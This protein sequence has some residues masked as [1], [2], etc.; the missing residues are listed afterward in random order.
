M[1]KK[2]SLSRQEDHWIPLSDLMTG[3]MMIFMLVAIVFMIQLKRDEARM[4]ESQERIRRIANLYVD[5]RAQLYSDL[6]REFKDDFK[7]WHASLR[8]DLT[9]RFEEPSVLFETG[10]SIVK[11]EFGTILASFFPRYVKILSSPKYKDAIEEL[12]IEGHTSSIWGSDSPQQA[13]YD[14]MRLSQDRTRSVLK[15]VFSLLGVQRDLSWLIPITTANGLSSSHR[16]FL[17]DGT[18]NYT[19]SQ[20]VEF[21]VRTNA[22]ERLAQ[23]LKE[24][25]R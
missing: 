5:L 10:Q 8:P 11:P 18:E 9:V 3:L 24:I 25:S 19:G 14:N 16:L 4:I 2:R 12:R 22:E 21:R 6:A 23:I 7:R 17:P 20:R 1:L 15:Y 13:Y